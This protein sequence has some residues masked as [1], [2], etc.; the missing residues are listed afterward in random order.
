VTTAGGT[1]TSGSN[2]NV[3]LPPAP[4]ISSFSPT[5]GPIGAAV[6]ILG[7]N[8]TGA[9]SV[10]FNG[11]AATF[12]VVSATR[13]DTAVPSGATSGK[14]S[15]TTPLGTGTSAGNFTISAPKITSFSPTSGPVGTVVTIL[16]S[17]FTG[18]TLV[19]FNKTTA[20]IFT[21]VSATR[22]DATVPAGATS[23]KIKVTTPGGTAQSGSNF[24]VTP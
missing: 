15:V 2:F 21:V 19:V 17:N 22:I 7:T 11:T 13:I 8:F 5:S 3:I 12:T 6:T 24:S 20:P 9:T 14:I 23:G 1:A 10:K 18:A 16:G 4:T